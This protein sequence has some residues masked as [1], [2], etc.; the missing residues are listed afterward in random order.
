[1]QR[2]VGFTSTHAISSVGYAIMF[3]ALKKRIFCGKDDAAV[4]GDIL[5]IEEAAE[6]DCSI[7]L[8]S[9]L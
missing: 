2:P 3:L 7:F 5:Y 8:L 4:D 1:M 6:S 9:M